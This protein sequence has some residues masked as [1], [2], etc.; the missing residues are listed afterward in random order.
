M[1]VRER[2]RGCVGEESRCVYI[3]CVQHLLLQK[4]WLVRLMV[5]VVVVVVESGGGGRRPVSW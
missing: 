3:V 1:C 5:M 4:L 2:H